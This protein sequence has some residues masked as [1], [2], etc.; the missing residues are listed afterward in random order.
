MNKY[1]NGLTLTDEEIENNPFCS[2]DHRAAFY[3]MIV[4]KICGK[5]YDDID[6]IDCRKIIVAKNI[7][8]SWYKNRP[9]DVDSVT[10]TMGLA[11]SGPKVDDSLQPGEVR[12]TD[13]CVTMKEEKHE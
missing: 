12:W 8:D 5:A 6:N 10:L 4:P 2:K 1:S 13:D 9:N 3:R 7:Q 11:I